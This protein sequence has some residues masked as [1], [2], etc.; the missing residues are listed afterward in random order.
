MVRIKKKKTDRQTDMLRFCLLLFV[1]LFVF[2]RVCVDMA[3]LACYLC[4]YKHTG[5]D[6]GIYYCSGNVIVFESD[7]IT[8]S[9]HN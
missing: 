6:E 9:S 4:G 2:V 7:V 3:F 5:N 1:C 8:I